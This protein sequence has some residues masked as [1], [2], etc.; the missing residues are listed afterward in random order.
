FKVTEARGLHEVIIYRDHDRDMH[1]L[2]NPE[3]IRVLRIFQ[4]RYLAMANYAASKYVLI[5]HNHGAG[6]GASIAHPHSQIISIPILPPDVK[7]SIQGSQDFYDKNNKRVY[8]LMIDWEMKEKKRIICENERFIAFCPFVSKTPYEVRIFPKESHAHFEKC[9]PE[10][11]A[12][13]GDVMSKVLNKIYGALGNPDYNFFIHT[14]PVDL[15]S[16]QVHEFYSWHIEVI[17]KIKMEGAFELGSGIEVNVIDP[18][19]A[20]EEL[21]GD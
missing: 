20:A 21:R 16:P 3:W 12:E 2:T 18:N 1:Q 7:R 8:D 13:L 6:A 15:K 19:Q 9:P 5:F 4:E 11:L 17:P 14:V 10:Q